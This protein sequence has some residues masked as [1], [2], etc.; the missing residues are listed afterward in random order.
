MDASTAEMVDVA[1]AAAF[2][3]ATVLSVAHRLP[4][5]MR[6]CDRVVVMSEGY[7]VEEGRPRC[8]K[9]S[10]RNYI[11]FNLVSSFDVI[12]LFIPGLHASDRSR[13][14]YANLL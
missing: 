7:V 9:I 6:H 3:D 2:E 1:M 4:S 5:V 10:S 12:L 8:G 11:V 14:L 13:F